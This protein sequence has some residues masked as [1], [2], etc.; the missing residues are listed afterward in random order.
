MNT[1]AFKSEV[2]NQLS[3]FKT[4]NIMINNN[5]NLFYKFR[6]HKG[7]NFPPIATKL[8]EAARRAREHNGK[9]ITVN[10]KHAEENKK[11]LYIITQI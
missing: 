5:N 3:K 4:A 7:L 11:Q 10:Y 2:R 9:K 8:V 1:C 6:L